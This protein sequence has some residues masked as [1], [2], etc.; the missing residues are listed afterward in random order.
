MILPMTMWTSQPSD[1]KQQAV[2]TLSTVGGKGRNIKRVCSIIPL[3]LE[4]YKPPTKYQIQTC[5]MILLLIYWIQLMK[6][7]I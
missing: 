1:M 7:Q 6:I 5:M 2:E 3:A 4:P